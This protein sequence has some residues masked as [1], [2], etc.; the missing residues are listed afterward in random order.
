VYDAVFD[1]D[2]DW[3]QWGGRRRVHGHAMRLA[4]ADTAASYADVAATEVIAQFRW[5]TEQS[6]FGVE[7]ASTGTRAVA[8]AAQGLTV[9]EGTGT[10]YV[11]PSGERPWKY[12]FE[13]DNDTPQPVPGDPPPSGTIPSSIFMAWLQPTAETEHQVLFGGHFQKAPGSDDLHT[14]AMLGL[15]QT[16]GQRALSLHLQTYETES[17]ASHLYS[18]LLVSP[19]TTWQ[20]LMVHTFFTK[21]ESGKW[22]Y[23]RWFLGGRFRQEDKWR[24]DG[25]PHRWQAAAT[26]AIELT[27][28]HSPAPALMGMRTTL[29]SWTSGGWRDLSAD[30]GFTGILDEV[31]VAHGHPI[32]SEGQ[33]VLPHSWTFNEPVFAAARHP[34]PAVVGLDA[35]ELILLGPVHDTEEGP[36]VAIVRVMVHFDRPVVSAGQSVW[37]SIRAHDTPFDRDDGSPAWSDWQLL[38]ADP[39]LQDQ[40]VDLDHQDIVGNHVQLRLRLLPSADEACLHSPVIT[41]VAY[42]AEYASFGVGSQILPSR[43]QVG[44]YADLPMRIVTQQAGSHDLA[45]RVAVQYPGAAVSL[46]SR[47]FVMGQRDVPARIFVQ[48]DYLWH[49]LPMR[50]VTSNSAEDYQDVPARIFVFSGT[51]S[52]AADRAIPSRIFIPARQDLP[53]QV[54]TLNHTLPSRILVQHQGSADL[55]S[56]I[57][58]VPELPGPVSPVTANTPE[59]IW[60]DRNS[61][62][63]SWSVAAWNR[64]PVTHYVWYLVDLAAWD[65]FGLH[66]A[67]PPQDE[68]FITSPPLPTTVL[69]QVTVDLTHLAYGSGKWAFVVRAVN[70]LGAAGPA[71]IYR[72]WYNHPPTAPA[73][74]MQVNDADSL[75]QIPLIRQ[76][77]PT[78][79]TWGV[80]TDADGDALSYQ[81]QVANHPE[82]GT[83]PNTGTNSIVVDTESGTNSYIHTTVLTNL[84]L[85]W[86]IRASDGMQSGPWG[87]IAAFRINEPP[88]RP[89]HTTVIDQS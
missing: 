85:W 45:A 83:N 49:D 4:F 2:A 22:I 34:D 71:A 81:I 3:N 73:S 11:I 69:T 48:P 33:P 53:V 51:A 63:L 52:A 35:D 75:S 43:I 23:V 44:A 31:V 29:P 54:T 7:A 5:G 56:R 10:A 17:R 82:F 14:T 38:P 70:T 19:T 66:A 42:E 36:G 16:D 58:T 68:S 67:V 55:S 86:R 30:R 25:G 26:G 28:H 32:L 15:H 46:D 77:P 88:G 39:L 74:V 40:W 47:L 41:R 8:L 64:Y 80:A 72:L 84:Q 6:L 20:H 62:T 37:A 79:F 9:G 65:V 50:I 59:A 61:V 87:P 24:V 18:Q 1:S 57:H 60:A 27:Q 21:D 13:V 89:T 12:L 76:T 78:T